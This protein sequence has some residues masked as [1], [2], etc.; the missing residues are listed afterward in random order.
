MKKD[1]GRIALLAF[2]R[3]RRGDGVLFGEHEE[4]DALRFGDRERRI[5][6]EDQVFVEPDA[7]GCERITQ[8]RRRHPLLTLRVDGAERDERVAA[9]QEIGLE[10]VLFLHAEGTARSCDDDDVA[11]LEGFRR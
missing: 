4:A 7:E 5:D 3:K 2:A 8:A 1:A 11:A 6:F 9:E 10:A